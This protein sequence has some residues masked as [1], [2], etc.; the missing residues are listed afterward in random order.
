[1]ADSTPRSQS[2]A[3]AP[4]SLAS[5]ARSRRVLAERT[6]RS[7]QCGYISARPSA[8]S[9]TMA[10]WTVGGSSFGRPVPTHHT[11]KEKTRRG[12]QR[13]MWASAQVML[14]RTSSGTTAS[15]A[16][17]QGLDPESFPAAVDIPSG[18]SPK[19]D[20][21]RSKRATGRHAGETTARR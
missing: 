8:A 20:G 1:M 10:A 19:G 21:L 13:M 2:A 18:T 3:A 5:L 17:P 12:L 7:T 6:D 14:W 4:A 15:A 16:A 9:A 11:A